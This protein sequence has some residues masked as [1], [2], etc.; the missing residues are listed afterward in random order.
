MAH[1]QVQWFAISAFMGLYTKSHK[2]ALISFSDKLLWVVFWSVILE[3]PD[4][5]ETTWSV[6]GL[7]NVALHRAEIR[8]LCFT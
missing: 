4:E 8:Q 5:M 3:N 7:S 1:N 6:D 2:Q